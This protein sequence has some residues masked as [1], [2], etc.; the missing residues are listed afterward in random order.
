MC[1]QQEYDT[2]HCRNCRS[3]QPSSKIKSSTAME[4]RIALCEKT[5]NVGKVYEK[6][7]AVYEILRPRAE[8]SEQVVASGRRH[9]I[10]K[11]LVVTKTEVDGYPRFN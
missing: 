9:E 1:D 7:N 2:N 11:E 5:Q 3:P 4:F 8:V 6:V 10:Q